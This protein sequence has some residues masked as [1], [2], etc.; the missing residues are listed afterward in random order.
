MVD[1]QAAERTSGETWKDRLARSE[2]EAEAR[3]AQRIALLTAAGIECFQCE[4]TGRVNGRHCLQCDKGRAAEAADLRQEHQRHI[5][6]IPAAIGIPPRFRGYTLDTFPDQRSPALAAVRSWLDVDRDPMR[7]GL[8][9]YGGFGRGKTGLILGVMRELTRREFV[10]VGDD[11]HSELRIDDHGHGFTTYERLSRWD[12]DPG[13]GR[14]A[15]FTT[16]TGLLESLR[17]KPDVD[18]DA[19]LRRYLS[20]P[21]LAIDDLGAERLTE[22]G[23]D[24]LFEI[25]NERHNN[26]L[27]LIVS[28][29]LSPDGLAKR[30]NRQ[31][32]DQTG[33]RIVERLVESCTVIAISDNAPNWRMTPLK[34]AA[35]NGARP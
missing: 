32:G 9:L 35:L 4:D 2:R 24:R 6:N 34:V 29:N 30:I 15:R 8:L 33:D 17:P 26:L 12:Y 3:H 14:F 10:R 28:S 23:A 1:L 22:W 5:A 18:D 7:P 13:F 31:L 16:S 27:P 19:T 20:C 21:Y 25:V 11:G